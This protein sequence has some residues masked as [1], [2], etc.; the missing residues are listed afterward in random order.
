MNVP[1]DVISDYV[2][3]ATFPV[4]QDVLSAIRDLDA[5]GIARVQYLQDANGA[6]VNMDEFSVTTNVSNLPNGQTPEQ[7]IRD[8]RSNINS[9]IDVR[10]VEFTEISGSMGQPDPTGTVLSISLAGGGWIEEGSEV[11]SDA[12]SSQW[13][14][15]TVLTHFDGSHPV[16]GNRVFG[17]RQNGNHVTIYTRGVDRMTTHLDR[18]ANYGGNAFS[19]ADALW[20]SFQTKVQAALEGEATMSSMVYRP[21]WEQVESVLNGDISISSIEGCSN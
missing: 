19:Q 5:F 2:D 10:G 11:V 1:C 17:F 13:I 20:K 3:L 7:F 8:I 12:S 15:T 4:S 9:Y 18:L 14:F 6:V 16:S 21:D